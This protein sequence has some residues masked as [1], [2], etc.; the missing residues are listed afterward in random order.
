MG[1]TMLLHSLPP[2]FAPADHVGKHTQVKEPG[3]NEPLPGVIESISLVG[4]MN[5]PKGFTFTI[6][7]EDLKGPN[8]Y[9]LVR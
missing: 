8:I 3:R 5:E 1:F 9:D 6:V 7:Y 4:T 2:E